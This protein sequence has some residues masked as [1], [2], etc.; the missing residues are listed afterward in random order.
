MI[1]A[2]SLAEKEAMAGRRARVK[3][4]A[5]AMAWLERIAGE[6][7]SH[8]LEPLIV[9]WKEGGYWGEFESWASPLGIEEQHVGR[10]L[11]ALVGPGLIHALRRH[12]AD[13]A[14]A[15]ILGQGQQ[16]YRFERQ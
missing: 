2:A 3:L 12:V 10:P 13:H 1:E 7:R 16:V 9:R 5:E 14:Q 11:V 15:L 8:E 4:G 6:Y